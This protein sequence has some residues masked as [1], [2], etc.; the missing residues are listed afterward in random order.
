MNHA[1]DFQTIDRERRRPGEDALSING[2]RSH[3][4]KSGYNVKWATIKVGRRTE[5]Y[6]RPK[7]GRS[8][9]RHIQDGLTVKESF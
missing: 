8:V 7:H 5:T 4:A 6:A 9:V 1:L 3:P 2:T